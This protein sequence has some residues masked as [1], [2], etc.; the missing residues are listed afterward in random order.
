MLGVAKGKKYVVPVVSYDEAIAILT[1]QDVQFE[2]SAVPQEARLDYIFAMDAPPTVNAVPGLPGRALDFEGSLQTLRADP[3]LTLMSGYL[4]VSLLHV[5]PAVA[6]IPPEIVAQVNNFLTQKLSLEAYDPISN[7]TFDWQISPESLAASLRLQIQGGQVT[8]SVNAAPFQVELNQFSA[9]INPNRW[10]DL[11]DSEDKLNQLAQLQPAQTA[12]LFIVKHAPTSYLIQPGDTLL[13]IAWNQG[14]PLWR[15]LQA[16][17]G[18]DIDNLSAGATITIPSKDDLLDRPI[19]LGKRILV[20]LSDQHL[21]GFEGDKLVFDEVISTGIDRSP[22][23]PGVFQVRSH[24]EN[25]YASVW[26]LYMPNFIGIYEAWPGFENGFH[27]LPILSG[28][29]TLWAGTLGQPVSYGCIILDTRPSARL[30]EWAEEGVI[31][32]IRE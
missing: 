12:P 4:N 16:N 26:D 2:V 23:Q 24:V 14:I 20:D 1:L 13:K 11:E 21:Y 15:I 32:E 7:E 10:L 6:E 27:G 8:L 22:T 25:A 30:Y 31:V 9:S 18:M 5:D 19:V 3:V 17:P 29:R 28:G